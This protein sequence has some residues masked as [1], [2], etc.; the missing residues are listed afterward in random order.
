MV[1]KKLA[2]QEDI[3]APFSGTFERYGA[4]FGWR[5]KEIR[6]VLLKNIKDIDGNVVSDHLWFT[7]T[8][9]FQSLGELSA[10]DTISFEA[11]VAAY[12]KGYVC[13]DYDAREVDF[14]LNYPTKMKKT[15]SAP[16]KT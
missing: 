8:K 10:G 15:L 5:G 2:E 12:I 3:R 14:K 16:N 1:R 9:R 6:T 7:E 4:K 13:R 11:R